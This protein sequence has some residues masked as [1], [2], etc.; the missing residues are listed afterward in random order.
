M[1]RLFF[2]KDT[3]TPRHQVYKSV[4]VFCVQQS[5]SDDSSQAGGEVRNTEPMH[6]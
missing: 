3:E 2:K 1:V 4:S 5:R 6:S